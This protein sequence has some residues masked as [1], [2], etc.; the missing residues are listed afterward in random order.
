MH[1]LAVLRVPGEVGHVE[2]A[3]GGED[4]GGVPPHPAVAVQ[5]GAVHALYVTPLHAHAENNIVLHC[6]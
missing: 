3:G 1:L 5:M 6:T 4:G 2:A